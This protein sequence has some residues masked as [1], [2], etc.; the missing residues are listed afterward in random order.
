MSYAV[1]RMAKMKSHDLKGIQFHN[2][3]ERESRTNPDIDKE[4]SYENYDL[5]NDE[6][7]DYNETSKRNYR[8]AKN[9]HKKNTEKMRC[10]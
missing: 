7:I 10:W 4:R 6:H 9:W 5:V 1:V 3:R 2:Q 8:I